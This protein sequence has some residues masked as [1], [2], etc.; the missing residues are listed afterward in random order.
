VAV[1]TVNPG[2]SMSMEAIISKAMQL[3]PDD[4]F[5][6]AKKMKVALIGLR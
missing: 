4:R 1:R 6:S 5:E 2:V 3:N